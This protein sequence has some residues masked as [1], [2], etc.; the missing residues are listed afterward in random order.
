VFLQVRAPV[1]FL[2]IVLVALV[3]WVSLV[4]GAL[5]LRGNSHAF[6][7]LADFA[8]ACAVTINY[9]FGWGAGAGEAGFPFPYATGIGEAGIAWE[10]AL[11]DI[12]FLAVVAGCVAV[13]CTVVE[14]VGER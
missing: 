8:L 12:A 4:R 7:V 11:V 14:L 9:A 1:E 13:E 5:G 3:Q 10:D 6:V 2:G